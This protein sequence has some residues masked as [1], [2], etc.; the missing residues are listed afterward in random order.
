MRLDDFHPKL[1][2][3]V[4]LDDQIVFNAA[5]LRSTLADKKD[6][7]DEIDSSQGQDNTQA[8]SVTKESAIK[9]DLVDGSEQDGY[10]LTESD[11][12]PETDENALQI[13][14]PPVQ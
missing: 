12:E 9:V 14:D 4:T 1:L 7:D 11:S 10:I 8:F 3:P 5:E 13:S 6:F 2:F